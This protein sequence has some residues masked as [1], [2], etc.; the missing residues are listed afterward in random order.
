MCVRNSHSL[1]EN[2][3]VTDGNPSHVFGFVSAKKTKDQLPC[4]NIE[5]FQKKKRHGLDHTMEIIGS[6]HLEVQSG[7]LLPTGADVLQKVNEALSGQQDVI[8]DT[9]CIGVHTNIEMTPKLRDEEEA[10]TSK[11]HVSQVIRALYRDL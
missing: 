5:G 7:F 4:S 3:E 1:E 2:R 8:K 6:K 9:M 10:T 11:K